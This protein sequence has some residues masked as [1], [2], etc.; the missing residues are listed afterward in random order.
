[1]SLL[2]KYVFFDIGKKF[3][4]K[5]HFVLLLSWHNGE[6]GQTDGEDL[7]TLEEREKHKQKERMHK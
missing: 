2:V 6:N 5:A 7:H 3:I 4:E 1:M